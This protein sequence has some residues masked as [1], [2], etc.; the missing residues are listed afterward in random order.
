MLKCPYCGS[1]RLQ[2]TGGENGNPSRR[3]PEKTVCLDCGRTIQEDEPGK[4][5]TPP[6]LS[7]AGR[8]MDELERAQQKNPVVVLEMTAKAAGVTREA[9]AEF[10]YA[11]GE[12]SFKELE[13]P[14][15]RFSGITIRGDTIELDGDI[16][17]LTN[18]VLTVEKHFT[19]Y[20]LDRYAWDETVIIKIYT[21]MK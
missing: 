14:F 7:A 8:R 16:S 12:Y 15:P 18:Q 4:G 21:D 10:P 20:G 1:N 3:R 11:D 5:L 6:D 9:K 13:Y 17:K 2:T 19:A